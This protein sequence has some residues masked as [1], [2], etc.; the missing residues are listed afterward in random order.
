MLHYSPAYR[1]SGCVH[2]TT[3]SLPSF[4]SSVL[5]RPDKKPRYVNS[6]VYYEEKVMRMMEVVGG[7]DMTY[8]L[9]TRE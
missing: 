7:L 4:R 9:S 8:S 3:P 2:T 1:L 5:P 6:G